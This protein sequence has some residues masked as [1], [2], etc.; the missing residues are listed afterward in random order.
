M[1]NAKKKFTFTTADGI[2]A[3]RTSSRAYTHV[4]VGR[5]NLAKERADWTSPATRL[6]LYEAYVYLSRCASTTVGEKFRD[7]RFVVTQAMYD[8][9]VKTVD[10]YPTVDTYVAAMIA[11]G[12]ERIN[13][14]EGDGEAGKERVLRWSRS[15]AAAQRGANAAREWHVDVRVVAL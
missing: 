5:R 8:E 15:V 7:G 1:K 14:Q 2:V 4:V 3:T 6:R 12:I 9:S 10:K 13:A 11:E